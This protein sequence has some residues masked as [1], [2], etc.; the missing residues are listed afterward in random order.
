MP[1]NKGKRR[2]L[3]CLVINELVAISDRDGLA[4]QTV[5]CPFLEG[6]PAFPGSAIFRES[7]IQIA[8]RDAACLLG[9][10]RPT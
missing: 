10:F 2:E 4:F 7:H 8:V 9:I 5:R 6:E 3:D 1:K